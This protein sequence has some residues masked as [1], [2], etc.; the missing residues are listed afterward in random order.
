MIF[1]RKHPEIKG[2]VLIMDYPGNRRPLGT[3]EPYTSG[4]FSKYPKI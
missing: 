3:F 1:K 4:E 2:Y